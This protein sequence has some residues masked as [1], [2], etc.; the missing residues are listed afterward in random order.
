[1][2]LKTLRKG[3]R[4]TESCYGHKIT[5]EAIEDAHEEGDS[6]Y[7]E[8]NREERTEWVRTHTGVRVRVTRHEDGRSTHHFGGP[9]GDVTVDKNGE[10]CCPPKK[11]TY[12]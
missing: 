7:P 3:D 1:M 6:V 8:T 2:K 12:P 5:L 11:R 10:E 4:F 9:V